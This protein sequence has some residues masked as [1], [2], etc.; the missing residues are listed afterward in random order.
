MKY[1]CCKE[2][3]IG[4]GV[5]I[6]VTVPLW[7]GVLNGNEINGNADQ[8]G[9]AKNSAPASQPEQE[10]DMTASDTVSKDKE[11]SNYVLGYEMETIEGEKKKLDAYRGK[12][13]LMVNVA[14]EC[15]FTPQYEG[16]EEMYRKYKKDGLVVIGFP[17]NNFGAQEP[18]TN[19]EIAQFCSSKFDVT[20][21]MMAK[22]SV[23]GK[24]AHP[25][26]K[27]L[28]AQPAPVG[29]E[30]EWNF[31]KFLVN[32]KGEVVARFKSRVTPEDPALLKKIQE[33][34]GEDS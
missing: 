25:L 24:D 9:T 30:P 20:F 21:P 16:L 7:A 14:S 34:L 8:D 6:A 2:S 22:I 31:D 11:V 3:R 12:V 1:L 27:Q 23:K 17:A 5:L 4:L 33:L 26:Y 15:G 13:V 29:G 32:R 10:K 28:A 18:G 19:A